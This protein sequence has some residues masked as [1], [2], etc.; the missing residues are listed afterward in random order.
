MIIR[1]N[2][3]QFHG[4]HGVHDEE[5]VLGNT[6][7]VNV[8]M[9]L[10]SSKKITELN[11]TVNYEKAFYIVKDRMN[12][13]TP[14]LETLARDIAES[15]YAENNYLKFVSV[16]IEKKFPPLATMQGS[17]GVIYKKEF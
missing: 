1:L 6:Y 8:E 14:L 13:P 3:L 9:G 4:Y 11:E 5:R 12:I 2:K 15:I 17:A 16:S 10:D 7:E